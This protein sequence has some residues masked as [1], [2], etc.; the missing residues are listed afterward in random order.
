MIYA[1]WMIH[2][3]N[4]VK[5]GQGSRTMSKDDNKTKSGFVFKFMAHN[6]NVS[7]PNTDAEWKNL[8]LFVQGKSSELKNKYANNA[9]LYTF[10]NTAESANEPDELLNFSKSF[11]TFITSANR[12]LA[13][14][15]PIIFDIAELLA[16]VAKLSYDKRV[17]DVVKDITEKLVIYR[18]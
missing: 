18:S 8:L 6:I 15:D 12:E 16:E 4:F 17:L 14:D 11:L 10:I 3:P 1:L 9:A 7:A 5:T 13:K 2:W